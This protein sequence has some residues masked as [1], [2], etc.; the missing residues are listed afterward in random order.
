[1][2]RILHRRG[3]EDA[4]RVEIGLRLERNLCEL[5]TT[6]R[7]NLRGLR[8]LPE[9]SPQRRR[10]RGVEK[11]LTE[12]DSELCALCVSAVKS[13]FCF[14]CGCAALGLCGED[15]SGILQRSC[16]ERIHERFN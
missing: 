3:A 2:L 1:M 9:D 15:Y 5:C 14:G 16:R 4:E 8:K 10:G 6:I 7:D 12:I 11:M 13:L